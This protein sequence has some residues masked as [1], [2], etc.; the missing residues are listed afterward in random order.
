MGRR[1]KDQTGYFSFMN[2]KALALCS[3]LKLTDT[4]FTEEQT[5]AKKGQA[6][7]LDHSEWRGQNWNP[8]LLIFDK[9]LSLPQCCSGLW[10]PS[11]ALRKPSL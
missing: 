6:C 7:G 5:E 8:V 1:T 11:L 9:G 3:F 10:C 4:H 2:T